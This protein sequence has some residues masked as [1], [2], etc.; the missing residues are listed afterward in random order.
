ME[1]DLIIYAKPMTNGQQTIY[2]DYEDIYKDGEYS[3]L[4]LGW[5]LSDETV[6]RIY[7]HELDNIRPRYGETDKKQLIR[8][9]RVWNELPRPKCGTTPARQADTKPKPR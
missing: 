1:P 5:Y 4:G 7:L 3:G 8:G 9:G 6:E 2:I